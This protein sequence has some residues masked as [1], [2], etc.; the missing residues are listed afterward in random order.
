MVKPS[1]VIPLD[2]MKTRRPPP[3][4][5]YADLEVLESADGVIGII[6]Q[7]KHNGVV[8]FTILREYDHFGQYKRTSF[9]PENMMPSYLAMVAL[10]S[11]R[12]AEIVGKLPPMHERRPVRESSN[13]NNNG[14]SGNR[15][16]AR[17]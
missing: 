16:G 13:G 10:L 17:R 3:A 1:D 9:F 5:S 14:N 4:N 15:R 11:K 2:D 6:S 8:T 7:H 12:M